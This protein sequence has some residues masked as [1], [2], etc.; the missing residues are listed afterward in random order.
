MRKNET[1]DHIKE[2]VNKMS[3]YGHR[4]TKL[5]T[6]SAAEFISNANFKRW[7]MD[8]RIIQEA[9]APYAKHQN[10]VVELL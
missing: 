5:R 4:V 10:G 7:L 2:F 9:S 3:A 1:Q 8:N 6:D